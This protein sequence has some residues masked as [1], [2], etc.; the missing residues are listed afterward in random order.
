MNH[1][2]G[3]KIQK[4]IDF[5][6]M[7]YLWIWLLPIP[8]NNLNILFIDLFMGRRNETLKYF[9]FQR[10]LNKVIFYSLF[11][12][13][14]LHSNMISLGEVFLHLCKGLWWNNEMPTFKD[15]PSRFFQNVF[16]IFFFRYYMYFKF[17]L[18]FWQ[19]YFKI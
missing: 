1:K 2:C 19:S 17:F 12:S 3:M 10:N 8:F 4:A 16:I 13:K 6:Q 15:E 14:I 5:P 7:Y 9:F 18:V 11:Q